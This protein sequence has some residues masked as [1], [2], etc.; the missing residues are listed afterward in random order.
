MSNH[1]V[2]PAAVSRTDPETLWELLKGAFVLSPL[3]SSLCRTQGDGR[4]GGKEGGTDTKS[5]Q[6]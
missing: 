6:L 2:L 1:S 3:N 4:E 5:L